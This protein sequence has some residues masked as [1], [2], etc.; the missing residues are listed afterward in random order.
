MS[1]TLRALARKVESDRF[2]L[3]SLLAAYAEA[4][5]LDD[6]GLA[7]ALG[8]AVADLPLLRLCRSPRVGDDAFWDEV[9]ALAERF[10]VDP[11]VLAD[12]VKRGGLVL[13]AREAPAGPASLLMAARDRKEEN[14]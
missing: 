12:A 7:A 11:H 14:T 1:E 2:F 6:A 4:E 10:G 9:R 3:A 8:C 13:L 5:G